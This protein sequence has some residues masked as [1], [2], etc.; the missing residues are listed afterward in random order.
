[1]NQNRLEICSS[2]AQAEVFEMG[3]YD[4]RFDSLKSSSFDPRSLWERV[5]GDAELL[6]ELVGIFLEE[7]PGLLRSIAAAIEQQSFDDVRKF[8]HKFKGSAL[9]L[10][11]SG[12]AA[13]AASLEQMGQEKSLQ[14]ANQVFSELERETEVLAQ[15]LRSIACRKEESAD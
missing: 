7:C 3:H 8:S 14:G 13:L 11:G 5:D 4:E 1:L 12:A 6:R 9:Q 10:S 15:S 2:G